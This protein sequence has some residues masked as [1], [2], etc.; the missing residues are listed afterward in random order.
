MSSFYA[1]CRA[2]LVNCLMWSARLVVLKYKPYIIAITGNV[3]KTSTKEAIYGVMQAMGNGSV[4]A[5]QKSFN[6]DIGLPLTIL[7]VGNPYKSP[8]AWLN[9]CAHIVDLLLFPNAYPKTLVLEVGADHPGDIRR[10]A[11]WLRPHVAIVT[12][13]GDLPVH[14]EFFGSSQ[15]VVDEKGYLPAAVRKGG[16]AILFNSERVLSLRTRVPEGVTVWTYGP[17]DSTAAPVVGPHAVLTSAGFEAGGMKGFIAADPQHEE[18][19]IHTPGVVGEH[20]LYPWVAAAAFVKACGRSLSLIPQALQHIQPPPGRMRILPGMNGTT[21]IDDT[22]NASPVA[23]GAA[24]ETAF[25]M[26]HSIGEGSLMM[27]LGDMLELGR[28][29]DEAH[30]AIG[31][32]IALE[33]R[34][35]MLPSIIITVGKRAR[36]IA[37]AYIKARQAKRKVGLPSPVVM[38]YDDAAAAAFGVPG[39]VG[40]YKPRLILLKGS[41]GLRLEKVV[42]VVLREGV[43]AKDVLV[44]QDDFWE[45]M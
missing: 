21:L 22:Y 38:S 10:M 37:E 13:I 28:Y 18:I 3:G 25:K 35:Y 31:T 44:R 40:Q 20:I 45:K 23:M 15:A 6:S 17:H 32:Y 39:L 24:I 7:G 16:V 33:E 29:S 19:T 14:I 43:V 36:G 26:G 27:V 34:E 2:G 41:Q 9:V 8:R 30:R 11:H 4:R 42:K 1:F 5:S 12:H